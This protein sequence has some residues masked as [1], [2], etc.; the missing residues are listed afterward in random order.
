MGRR[1]C[2]PDHDPTHMNRI[3]ILFFGWGMMFFRKPTSTFGSNPGAG[4]FGIMPQ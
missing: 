4:F 1:H 2:W 3:A